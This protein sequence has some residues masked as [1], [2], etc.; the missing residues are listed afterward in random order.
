MLT[1]TE[2]KITRY[3]LVDKNLSLLSIDTLSSNLMSEQ[4]DLSTVS[5]LSFFSPEHQSTWKEILIDKN[6]RNVETV[7]IPLKENIAKP[8]EW[9]IIPRETIKDQPEYEIFG[10]VSA[11]SGQSKSVEK[12]IS[13][14]NDGDFTAYNLYQKRLAKI[15][16]NFKRILDSSLDMICSCDEKGRF[17]R[18]SAACRHL[19]GREPRE[20]IGKYFLDYVFEEDVSKTI[21]VNKRIIEGFGTTNFENRYYKKDGTLATLVW[22]ARW[23]EADKKI[24]CVARDATEKKASEYALKASEEKYKILFYNHPLPSW[25][26]DTETLKFLEVNEAAVNRYGYSREEFSAM[27]I[28]DI[29]DEKEIERFK[30]FKGSN[31]FHQKP[32]KGIWGNKTR[33]GEV[34]LAEITSNNIEYQGKLARLVIAVDR[35]EQLLAEEELIESNRKYVMLS[36]ATFDAIWD[37]EV[38]SEIIKWNE[39]VKKMF[40]KPDL[41]TVTGLDW[42]VN[43]LHPE[44]RERVNKK[45]VETIQQHSLHW[46]DE[47]RFK[48]NDDHYKY[49][50]AR[51]YFLYDANKE[52]VRM[53]GAMQD[54]TERKNHENT[55]QKLNASLEKRA[56]ELAE[57]NAE[58]ERFAY[59]ASHDLQEPLRMVTSFLQLLEKRYHD[60]LDKKAHE[61]IAYA[62]DG[63]DRMKKLI[64]DLLEYSRVNSSKLEKED[65]SLKDVVKDLKSTYKSILAE[66]NGVIK[67][68]ELPVVRGN[69]TQLMQL[70][71]N[72]VGNAFKYRSENP[73]VIEI[74]Y[75]EENNHYK[76]SISDNGIGID[77]K[78]FT[79]I[80]VIFQRLHNREQYSGTGI[81][82]AICK[83][84]IEK[85]GG[86][87]WVTSVPNKGST[88]YFTIPKSK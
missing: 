75:E 50:Y 19:L 14:V 21:E 48:I 82:L 67:S 85:H 57:S 76:F 16:T 6:L 83:K 30:D 71:Q 73:P 81:G 78:F 36:E 43:N 84:I 28:F 3:F 41:T 52:P 33:N 86:R 42:W 72:I 9:R 23:D 61:Y 10:T 51:G 55:L 8:I 68:G 12:V 66:T 49:I 54:L 20:L 7:K 4:A 29:L 87:I 25:I 65:V 69:K 74:A 63:A 77:P 38:K 24:Y 88:F 27:N 13:A 35:T 47:Y 70:F 15:L 22:S 64:L 60:K 26:Y 80:F 31:G 59:V 44:D 2:T 53:I 34:I 56:K 18:V 58:L 40:E 5:F 1:M 62:V 46:E 32:S 11:A 37:W 45:I 79:K 17:L 39:G